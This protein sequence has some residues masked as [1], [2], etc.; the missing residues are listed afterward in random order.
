MLIFFGRFFKD[1]FSHSKTY[2][3]F[4]LLNKSPAVLFSW[5][6]V[7]L[8]NCHQAAKLKPDHQTDYCTCLQSD[9]F[10]VQIRLILV[11]RTQVN[12]GLR[13]DLLWL[14]EKDFEFESPRMAAQDTSLRQSHLRQL[15]Y[16][17][18]NNNCLDE[19]DESPPASP[20]G[21]RRLAS[22]PPTPKSKR[23]D[24]G[25]RDSHLSSP[26]DSGAMEERLLARRTSLSA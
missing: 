7:Q 11:G 10:S 24:R 12:R 4:Q 15:L 13:I 19:A 16:S 26:S 23:P 17:Q 6:L 3:K 9:R 20:G 8:M 1:T 5:L 22:G 21:H 14:S 18:K 25:K 2:L